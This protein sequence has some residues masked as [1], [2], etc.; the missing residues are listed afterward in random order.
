MTIRKYTTA[1]RRKK[2]KEKLKSKEGIFVVEKRRHPRI[3]FELPL[4]YSLMDSGETY[5]GIVGN[6]SEGDFLFT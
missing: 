5:G 3:R 1:V 6:A 2:G 4:D